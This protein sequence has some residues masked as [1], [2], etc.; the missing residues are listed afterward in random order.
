[1]YI[2]GEDIRR[3]TGRWQLLRTNALT[4]TAI[5]F[6]ILYQPFML[7]LS[8]RQIDAWQTRLLQAKASILLIN[9]LPDTRLTKILY[10][11]VQFL[12]EKANALDRL[13]LLRPQ[14]IKTN[15]VKLMADDPPGS[16]GELQKI[17]KTEEGYLAAGT[18]DFSQQGPDAIILAYQIGNSDPMAFALTHPV[19]PPASILR[20]VARTGTWQARFTAAQLPASS[21]TITAWG[22]DATSGRVFRLSGDTQIE[23][24]H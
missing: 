23:T 22:F 12:V 16:F 1:M 17:Q 20:G 19:K 3:R 8:Y 5:L 21:A 24:T 6:L 15:D 14:L 11:N 10:P 2:I 7:A 9:P 18:C 4:F 13:G